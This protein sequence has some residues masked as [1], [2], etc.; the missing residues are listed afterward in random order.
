MPSSGDPAWRRDEDGDGWT[1]SWRHVAQSRTSNEWRG[2]LGFGLGARPQ[3]DFTTP[4]DHRT[5]LPHRDAAP[6]YP[7]EPDRQ[8]SHRG[9]N[10]PPPPAAI[11]DVPS[12][13]PLADNLTTPLVTELA[14][15]EYRRAC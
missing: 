3:S 5:R 15:S 6:L 1:V 11:P 9:L 7:L 13:S 12:V 10:T 8:R 4:S 14:G 2:D